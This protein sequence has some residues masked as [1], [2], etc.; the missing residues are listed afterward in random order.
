MGVHSVAYAFPRVRIITTAVDKEVNDQFHII[1]G[2]G[3]EVGPPLSAGDQEG[4]WTFSHGLG[5]PD[6]SRLFLFPQGTSGIVTLAPTHL[7]TG[8]R[9][10]KGWTADGPDSLDAMET[11]RRAVIPP[12]LKMAA[13]LAVRRNPDSSAS[14]VSHLATAAQKHRR[15]CAGLLQDFAQLESSSPASR[16]AP[17][18]TRS[19]GASELFNSSLHKRK[20]GVFVKI[21]G[22][23]QK[24]WRRW[25][26]RSFDAAVC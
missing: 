11:G 2:I 23:E 26:P 13:M 10:M 19:V 22:G 16:W 8:V 14:H 6:G 3:E 5:S 4:T 12:Y 15:C 25:T 17:L 18:I 24:L 7:P 21:I 1:P 20:I 9:A